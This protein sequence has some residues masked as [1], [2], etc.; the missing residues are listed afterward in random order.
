MTVV[1]G[2]KVR[3][4]DVKDDEILWA[5]VRTQTWRSR[6]AKLIMVS[7]VLKGVFIE[8]FAIPSLLNNSQ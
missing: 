3:A 1:D 5:R 7:K 8:E 6:V 2:D 4:R